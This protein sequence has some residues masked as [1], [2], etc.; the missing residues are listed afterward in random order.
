MISAVRLKATRLCHCVPSC[1]FPWPSFWRSAVASENEATMVPPFVE[2][3]SG[4]LPTCPTKIA[5]LTP[6]DI[7]VLLFAE[8]S[9]AHMFERRCSR[10]FDV[11]SVEVAPRNPVLIELDLSGAAHV[12]EVL[13]FRW[14]NGT[15]K[16]SPVRL[17]DGNRNLIGVCH[18]SCP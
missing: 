6:F 18:A 7:A 13:Q 4:S 15:L 16:G 10:G 8:G 14:R 9:A 2:R 5:L 17:A 12:H 11:L 3:I 1:Q